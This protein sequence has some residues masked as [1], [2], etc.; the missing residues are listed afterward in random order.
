LFVVNTSPCRDFR[1]ELIQVLTIFIDTIGVPIRQS[2][3]AHKVNNH[4]ERE[5]VRLGSEV[6]KCTTWSLLPKHL[7]STVGNGS[8]GSC[9]VSCRAR[10]LY[11]AEI[12]D[13]HPD[14]VTRVMKQTVARLKVSVNVTVC[15]QMAQ[16]RRD[17]FEEGYD[18]L[19]VHTAWP[20]HVAWV[21][22]LAL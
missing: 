5:N 22:Q 17:V 12:A 9:R 11:F 10:R 18:F 7:W 4:A 19:K 8:S 16:A 20:M 2:R 14:L 13:Q 1:P 3:K 6:A 15:M 21:F